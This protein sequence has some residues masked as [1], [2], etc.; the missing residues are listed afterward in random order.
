M[1]VS[2]KSPFRAHVAQY[3][4]LIVSLT[5][6]SFFLCLFGL[7]ASSGMAPEVIGRDLAWFC[8][9]WSAVVLLLVASGT[10]PSNLSEPS[11]GGVPTS[12]RKAFT[13]LLAF[14][15]AGTVSVALA[16]TLGLY[17][18]TGTIWSGFLIMVTGTLV[19]LLPLSALAILLPSR[20]RLLTQRSLL[21]ICL[22]L[23]HNLDAL[24]SH[25]DT[26]GGGWWGQVFEIVAVLI[27]DQGCPDWRGWLVFG[28]GPEL[29]VLGSAA[30]SSLALTGFFL[31]LAEPRH[32]DRPS[33]ACQPSSNR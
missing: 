30:L 26:L 22:T 18:A 16:V 27:P 24:R 15:L 28:Q 5:A 32:L 7:S 19:G 23:G 3:G 14:W 20:G 10:P 21:L 9:Y 2:A 8:V 4:W 29:F 1:S 11:A 33:D 17:V 25:L 12:W 13:G 31:L 6:L